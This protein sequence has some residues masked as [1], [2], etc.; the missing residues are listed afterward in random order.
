MYCSIASGCLSETLFSLLYKTHERTGFALCS[1]GQWWTSRG[2][3]T[4][5]A[6]VTAVLFSL[7]MCTNLNRP[8]PL[9]F[10]SNALDH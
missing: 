1:Y 2:K 8:K 6:A 7:R 5:G 3:I 9:I 4:A 10:K